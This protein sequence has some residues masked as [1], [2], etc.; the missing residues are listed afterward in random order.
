MNCQ[1]ARKVVHLFVDGA[2]DPRENVDVL[3]HLNMCPACSERFGE[4]KKFEDFLK[5]KLKPEPAPAELRAKI[6]GRLSELAS[7][8]PLRAAATA[9]RR[10]VFA[11]FGAAAVLALAFGAWQQYGVMSTCPFVVASTEAY[12]HPSTAQQ[13]PG[14]PS[15]PLKQLND[16]VPNPPIDGL[17]RDGSGVYELN[18][19]VAVGRAYRMT[20]CEPGRHCVILFYVQAPG[21]PMHDHNCTVVHGRKFSCWQYDDHRVV[22]WKETNSGFYCL[23]VCAK[24]EMDADALVNYADL[25]APR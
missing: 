17:V 6:S 18:G 10:P 8:W 24:D 12:A 4:A 21:L 5:D 1:E 15:G 13:I 3:A 19:H 20:H 16:S 14:D 9:R 22:C 11:T 25:A 23:M 2:L 7:P